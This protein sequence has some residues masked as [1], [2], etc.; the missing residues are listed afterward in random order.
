MC[1]AVSIAQKYVCVC[2]F[3]RCR[4]SLG[5]HS[6][7][8]WKWC[9]NGARDIIVELHKSNGWIAVFHFICTS[10]D[11]HFPVLHTGGSEYHLHLMNTRLEKSNRRIYGSKFISGEIEKMWI[12]VCVC[13]CECKMTWR[14]NLHLIDCCATTYIERGMRILYPRVCS[15]SCSL[16]KYFPPASQ[17]N[18]NKRRKFKAYAINI[19]PLCSPRCVLMVW[20]KPMLVLKCKPN[21]WKTIF[22][23][24][25][26]NWCCTR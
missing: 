22:N 1:R 14:N 11:P 26:L 21:E 15:C 18:K 4:D 17:R 25:M 9:T 2:V 8:F 24:D 16:F 12:C 5:S 20:L 7:Q 10:L 19:N 23:E 13:Q 6:I 3:A